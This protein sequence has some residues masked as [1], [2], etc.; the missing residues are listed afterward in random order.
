[1]ATDDSGIDLY[2]SSDSRENGV[3][4]DFDVNTFGL[5]PGDDSQKVKLESW[6]IPYACPNIRDDMSGAPFNNQILFQRN[7]EVPIVINIPEGHYD[8]ESVWTMLAIEANNGAYGAQLTGTVRFSYMTGNRIQYMAGVNREVAVNDA[9]Y[10]VATTD[11]HRRFAKRLGILNILLLNNGRLRIDIANATTEPYNELSD[12]WGEY[13]VPDMN[14]RYLDVCTNLSTNCY[15][16]SKAQ[17]NILKRIFITEDYGQMISPQSNFP[18]VTVMHV[19][20]NTL[21]RF[22]LFLI[23]D[24]GLPFKLPNYC[25]TAFHF[26]I[27]SA[28]SS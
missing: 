4:Y 19:H 9:F 11:V 21:N 5:W 15:S 16:N 10:L 22:R 13:A 12:D 18:S 20:S 6:S 14:I 23:A 3:P 28:H 27:T 1:M 2:I 24:D 26:S 7:N 8:L 25:T 17:H